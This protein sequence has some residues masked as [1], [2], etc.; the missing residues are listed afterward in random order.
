MTE[1]TRTMSKTDVPTTLDLHFMVPA[2]SKLVSKCGADITD[3]ESQHEN[4]Q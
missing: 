4:A 3:A 2:S 1:L